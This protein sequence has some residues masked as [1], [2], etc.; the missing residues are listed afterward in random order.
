LATPAPSLV[1]V[2]TDAVP[3]EIGQEWRAWT[4]DQ[5]GSRWR[6]VVL[7]PAQVPDAG[8][9]WRE[10]VCFIDPDG[11]ARVDLTRDRGLLQALVCELV[12]RSRAKDE[13]V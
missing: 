9:K 3:A 6:L 1:L 5:S 2:I 13:E 4:S 10:D 7:A 8:A 11:C 12:G